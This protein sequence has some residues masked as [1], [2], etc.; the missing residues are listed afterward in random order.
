MDQALD[1]ILNYKGASGVDFWAADPLLERTLAPLLPEGDR[2]RELKALA[3]FGPV[4][5]G[6]LGALVEKAHR[7][8]NL[9]RLGKDESVA[10]CAEQKEARSILARRLYDEPL[11]FPARMAVCVL[12]NH[13]GEGG[14]TCPTA[15]N[16]GLI[17]LLERSGTEAQKARALPV[18]KSVD[19]ENAL[20]AGQ[21]ITERQGGS[22]VGANLTTAALQADGA[23]LLNGLKWFC[24]NPGNIWATTA[25]LSGTQ[26]VGLFLVYHRLEDGKLNGHH[27][28]KLKEICGTKGKGTAEI[29]Y[30][31]VRAELI[32]RG[33]QGMVLLS[34]LLGVSRIHV[35]AAALGFI[36]RCVLEAK[37]FAKMR[38]AYGRRIETI[39]SVAR[40]LAELE[41]EKDACLLAF[42]EGVS[43]MDKDEP[44]AQALVPL[45]KIEVSKRATAVIRQT[46]LLIGGH[47]ILEDFTVMPR[48]SQDSIVNE[49]WEGTHP[50]L[51]GHAV[52]ALRR[53]DVFADFAKRLEGARPAAIKELTA[54]VAANRAMSEDERSLDDEELCT[55]AFQTLTAALL[56]R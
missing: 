36:G 18:L 52:K 38:E 46:Q 2:A 56:S 41:L 6:K 1:P 50:I 32:G 30:K 29:E 51:A 54:R 43:A 49:I 39:P 53:A 3:A 47:G 37:A 27:L 10:Y 35:A 15:M 9:P 17:R 45:L 42:F 13:N 26:V 55:L 16:E 4:C 34:R 31:D 12:A 21:Q 23:W 28:D 11:S 25:K 5:G 8:E 19:P 22:N 24:S 48:L 33:S 44:A 20:P 7:P 14:I 40:T